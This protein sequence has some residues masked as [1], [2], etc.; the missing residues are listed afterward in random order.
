MCFKTSYFVLI[1]CFIVTIISPVFAVQSGKLDE[2]SFWSDHTLL[3]QVVLIGVLGI[4]TWALR[5]IINGWEEYQK[6]S[7]ISLKELNEK[8]HSINERVCIIETKIYD[9][10]DYNGPERRNQ[11]SPL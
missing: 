1:L 3:V 11:P 7:T 8:I 4:M 6:E 5:K 2:L 9:N 10:I